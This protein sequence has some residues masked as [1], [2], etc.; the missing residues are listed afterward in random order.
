MDSNLIIVS[1]V[2]VEWPV[3]RKTISQVTGLQ[4]SSMI[5]QC[6]VNFSPNA[7]FLL[8]AAYLIL[9]STEEDPHNLLI[10][11]P[12]EAMDFLHYTFLIA[13]NTDTAVDLREKTRAHYTMMEIERGY[14]VL[15][16]GPLSVWFDAI[17]LN[18]T[19]PRTMIGS[20]RIL[21]DKMMLLLEKEG[22]HAIFSKFNKKTLED[23]TFLLEES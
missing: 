1:R 12:R 17:V 18:L 2:K 20:T 23:K 6:P 11:L 4:P 14:C 15:G 16:T 3:L 7:E 5:D 10:N 22:L 13:C 19:H 8:F 21:F 9:N